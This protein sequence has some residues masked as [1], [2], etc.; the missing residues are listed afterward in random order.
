MDGSGSDFEIYDRYL[1]THNTCTQT[2]YAYI[3]IY[4]YIYGTHF[5]TVCVSEKLQWV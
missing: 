2:H 1:F 5:Y 4:I 3:F